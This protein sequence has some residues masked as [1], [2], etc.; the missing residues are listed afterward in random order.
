MKIQFEGTRVEGKIESFDVK[1]NRGSVKTAGRRYSFHVTSYSSRRTRT[2]QPDDTV[3]LVL[4]GSAAL[5]EVREKY[6]D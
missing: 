2:P 4:D 6:P 1:T 5:L 3:E